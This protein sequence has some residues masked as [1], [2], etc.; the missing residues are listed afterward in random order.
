MKVKELIALLSER[1]PEDIV[2]ISGYETMEGVYVAEADMLV[3]MQTVQ[4]T[5]RVDDM[6]GNRKSVASQ[7]ESSVWIGW[8]DDY[9]TKTFLE[10]ALNPEDENG[11]Q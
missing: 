11:E 8:K 10:D 7:G 1:N 3:P 6:S 4:V 9:R 5:G 2:L